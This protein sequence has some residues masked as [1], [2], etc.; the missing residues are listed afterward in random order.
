[1]FLYNIN[2]YYN[3]IMLTTCA[4]KGLL[5]RLSTDKSNILHNCPC[6]F[7]SGYITYSLLALS[8]SW[9]LFNGNYEMVYLQSTCFKERAI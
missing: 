9:H 1:M 8:Q 6:I 2:I 7:F 3:G 4:Y 5:L